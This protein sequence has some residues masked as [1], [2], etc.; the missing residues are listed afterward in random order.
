MN[1]LDGPFAT[2]IIYSLVAAGTEALPLARESYGALNAA[3]RAALI[4]LGDVPVLVPAIS[5]NCCARP[6]NTSS[7]QSTPRA[8]RTLQA[9]L[10]RQAKCCSGTLL[11]KRT[12]VIGVPSA[13]TGC[14]RAKFSPLNLS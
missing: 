2:R 4:P 1:H 6:F 3:S 8:Y 13:R 14:G 9:S 11:S 10:L 7:G 5:E 12:V